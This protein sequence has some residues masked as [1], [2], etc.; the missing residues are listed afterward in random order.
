MDLPLEIPDAIPV[1]ILPGVVL[2]P[3]VV[4]PL[5]IFEPRYRTM[6]ESILEGDRLFAVACRNPDEASSKRD[7][8]GNRCATVGVVRASQ[9]NADGTSSLI[10]QGIARVRVVEQLQED[11][12]PLVRIEP[13]EPAP[14]PERFESLRLEL[15]SQVKQDPHLESDLPT[16]FVEFIDSIE[17]PEVYV[18]YLAYAVCSC[19]KTKQ[20]LLETIDVRERYN[21]FLRYL[22]ERA[23]IRKRDQRLQGRTRDEEISLN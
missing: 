19:P 10:L 2:F 1:M 6:L 17:D 22:E 9:R 16:E 4:L 13:I 18:D 11:P 20:R 8:I 3:H 5:H 12:F 14:A 7:P 21:V 15:K 23:A